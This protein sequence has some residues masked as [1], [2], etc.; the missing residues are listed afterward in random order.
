M[1]KYCILYFQEGRYQWLSGEV[2]FLNGVTLLF[3]NWSPGEPNNAGNEDCVELEIN[4]ATGT[5]D[6]NDLPCSRTVSGTRILRP[7]CKQEQT[8]TEMVTRVFLIR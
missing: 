8:E 7:I 2:F 4:P 3:T 1:N 5:S 6:W